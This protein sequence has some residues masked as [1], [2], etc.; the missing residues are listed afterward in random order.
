MLLDPPHNDNLAPAG[1][2][3]ALEQHAADPPHALAP[4]A[5]PRSPGRRASPSRGA[6]RLC[7]EQ[8]QIGPSERSAAMAIKYGRPIEA[9]L[10]PA[11]ARAARLDLSLRPRR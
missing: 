7:L 2:A 11:E 10:A 8:V 3:L 5:N 9:R 1:G 4:A 6:G